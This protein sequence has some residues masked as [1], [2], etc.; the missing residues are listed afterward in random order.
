MSYTLHCWL[1]DKFYIVSKD[2]VSKESLYIHLGT[3]LFIE[4]LNQPF[5]IPL[6]P[7]IAYHTESILGI[8]T[9]N[10]VWFTLML[11][12]ILPLWNILIDL[13]L[14]WNLFSVKNRGTFFF[15]SVLLDCHIDPQTISSIIFRAKFYFFGQK[16]MN[17]SKDYHFKTISVHDFSSYNFF[18]TKLWWKPNSR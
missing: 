14:L 8:K 7:G 1:V 16:I 4:S 13:F 9:L 6:W 18:L 11:F 2:C 3:W 15:S 10:N 12:Y 5:C 17:L